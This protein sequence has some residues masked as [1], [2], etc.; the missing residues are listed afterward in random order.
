[1]QN[2]K[3]AK[4]QTPPLREGV[5]LFYVFYKLFVEESLD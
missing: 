4:K 3:Y 1:M 5:Y 2:A